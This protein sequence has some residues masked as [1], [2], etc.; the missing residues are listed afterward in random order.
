MLG[1]ELLDDPGAEPAAVRAQ[2]R[3]IARLNTLFGGTRA[4]LRALDPFFAR[5]GRQ[6]TGDGEP[7]TLL[8]VGTGAGDIPRA[9][10]RLARRHGVELTLLGVERIPAAARLARGAGVTI[11]LAD[12]GALPLPSRSVDIVMASQVLHHLPRET[13]VRWIAAMD[14][15]ARRAVVLADL[16]RSR[17]AIAGMWA[18]SFP[19]GCGARTRHDAVLSLRR[20]YTRQELDAM[21]RDAGVPARSYYAPLAR[22][23][24]VWKPG[25]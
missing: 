25:D 6:G 4:V 24:A 12:G 11:I 2:L 22:V 23:V 7:W 16:R 20:G 21:L 8:D 15:V 5:N 13:A 19:L 3:D 10:R 14:R 18:V 17:A 9:A 1:V